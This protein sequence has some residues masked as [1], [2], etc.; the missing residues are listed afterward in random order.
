MG[1]ISRRYFALTTISFAAL[2]LPSLAT[3]QETKE[4]PVRVLILTGFDVPSHNW[5]ATTPIIRDAMEKKGGCQVTVCEDLGILESSSLQKYDVIVLNFGF[6]KEPE[7]SEP[8]KKALVDF[9]KNGK[10]LVALHFACSAF[11][12]WPEYHQLLGRVWKKG[13]GGH[14]PMSTFEVKIA[15]P[16]HPIAAGVDNFRIKDELYA[17]LSGDAPIHV[18]A[19]GFSDWSNK[20]EPLVFTHQYG[21]GRVVQ[22]VLGHTVESRKMPEYQTLLVNGVLWAA[23]R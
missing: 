22:N 5:R 23:G 1:R 2:L 8:A 6:W 17:R 19:E 20:V 7:P 10:G 3:A 4:A 21:K 9:V 12:E 18:V 15:D 13:I 14:G 11:Q 16:Q